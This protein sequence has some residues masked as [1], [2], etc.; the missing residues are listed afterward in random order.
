MFA[1]DHPVLSLER[2]ST[3]AAALR[4]DDEIRDAWL[5]Q[6]AVS[7]FFGADPRDLT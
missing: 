4:L 6:N 5:Y 3:E 7:F 1:S 2:C